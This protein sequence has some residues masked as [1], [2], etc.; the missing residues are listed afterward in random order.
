M[1]AINIISDCDW[2]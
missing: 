2:L 1:S